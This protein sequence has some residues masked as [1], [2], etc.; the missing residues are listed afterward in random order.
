MTALPEGPW[1]RAARGAMLLGDD[2]SLR[3]SIFGEM[4]ALAAATGSINLGQGFP[5]Y[6]G[7]SEVLDAARDAIAGNPLDLTYMEYEL[8]KFLSSHPGKV[9]TRDFL[10]EQLWGAGARVRAFD[11]EAMKETT[12]IYG[13]RGDLVLCSDATQALEGADALVVSLGLDTFAGDPISTF[14]LQGDDF[15]RLG[16]RLQALGLPTAFILEGGYAAAELADNA[17][18]VIEGFES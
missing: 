16:S 2:G 3:G 17:V 13:E 15:S 11:P 8:L 4:S 10:L 1:Q 5:D 7:P 9:F 18:A 6:D 14:K 12:R